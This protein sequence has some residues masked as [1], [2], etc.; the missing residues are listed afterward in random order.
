MPA[1]HFSSVAATYAKW[2]P[3]YPQAMIAYLA[4]LAP[5]RGLA[6]DCATGSGQA[7]VLLAQ[8]VDRV[9]GTDLSTAQISHAEPHP[10]VEYRHGAEHESGLP[11][12]CCDLVTVAQ[13]AHWL[14]LPAF[15]EE[16]ARVLKP[17]GLLAVWGYAVVVVA[18]RSIP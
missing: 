3:S 17:Q 16:T 6:W 5:G 15:Y 8:A 9:V 2:R 4:G 18:P 7:A 10:R 13:A 14:N 1:D 12:E 11:D